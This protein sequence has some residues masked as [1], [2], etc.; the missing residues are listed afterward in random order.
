MYIC[1]FFVSIF[2]VVSEQ[3]IKQTLDNI[4]IDENQTKEIVASFSTVVDAWISVSMDEWF[5]RLQ[6]TLA[7]AFPSNYVITRVVKHLSCT[8]T[9]RSILLK[10]CRSSHLCNPLFHSRPILLPTTQFTYCHLI[11]TS[12]HLFYH[13]ICMSC[14]PLTLVVIPMLK[15]HK[16][17]QHFLFVNIQFIPTL[18]CKLPQE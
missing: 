6:A 1:V 3:N 16:F 5:H 12:H 2:N 15:I 17:T 18:T 10:Q 4:T 7:N 9:C 14:H 11:P 8:T 13:Q